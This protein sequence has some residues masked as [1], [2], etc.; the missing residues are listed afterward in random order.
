MRLA[1]LFAV[2]AALIQASAPAASPGQGLRAYVLTLRDLPGGF[3]TY[4]S[5][6]R[7]TKDA[8]NESGASLAKYGAWG[9]IGGWG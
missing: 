9:F 8:A 4:A 3:K 2:V 7:T 1:A 6:H 5:F